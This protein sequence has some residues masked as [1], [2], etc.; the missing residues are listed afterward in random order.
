[1]NYGEAMNDLIF[2][3]AHEVVE[4]R[5][6]DNNREYDKWFAH[7]EATKEKIRKSMLANEQVILFDKLTDSY[8]NL[9]NIDFLYMAAQG[10]RFYITHK[11]TIMENDG[12][13]CDIADLKSFH[14][15]N[16][17]L[18]L[19]NNIEIMKENLKSKMDNKI[20]TEFE[21]FRESYM[22]NYIYW[23]KQAFIYAN[24]II[25]EIMNLS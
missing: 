15:S 1:M 4:K 18:P 12:N 25:S 14:A 3:F 22:N 17:C 16:M 10:V 20:C 24:S 13:I 5:I 23:I 7:I 9:Y 8:S 11:R 6:S 21:Q 19:L 2:S